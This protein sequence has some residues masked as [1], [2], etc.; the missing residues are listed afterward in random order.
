MQCTRLWKREKADVAAELIG[1]FTD[2]LAAGSTSQDVIDAF[3]DPRTAAKL[4]RRATIRKRPLLWHAWRWGGR[5]VEGV[6]LAYLLLFV[7]FY[8]SSP[9]ITTDYQAL[10]ESS[11]PTAAP[12]DCGFTYYERGLADLGKTDG[13]NLDAK[14]L[15]PQWPTLADWLRR[16]ARGIDLIRQGAAK[17][18]FGFSHDKHADSTTTDSDRSARPDDRGDTMFPV[19][20]P[21]SLDCV[22]QLD[23]VLIADIRLHAL[24]LEADTVENDL[25]AIQQISNQVRPLAIDAAG[26]V[27]LRSEL[28][29][30]LVLE[31]TLASHPALFSDQQLQRI[32]H[33]LS[34]VAPAPLP[35]DWAWNRMKLQDFLQR[36][37]TPGDAGRITWKGFQRSAWMYG[38][39][40][41]SPSAFVAVN[42][43]IY[44]ATRAEILAQYDQ[45]IAEQQAELQKPHRER[46]QAILDGQWVRMTSD[47]KQLVR[48]FPLSAA[49]PRIGAIANLA[50]QVRGQRDGALVGIALEI[51]HRRHGRY[52]EQLSDLTPDLLPAVPI[53]RMNGRPVLYRLKGQHPAG[54]PTACP[55]GCPIV[56]S[57][58]ADRDDDGG[59]VPVDIH[60]VAIPAAAIQWNALTPADGDWILY[61]WPTE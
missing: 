43:G 55:S 5:I 30:V 61:P 3:G 4:I 19:I 25:I 26:S 34:R 48:Y 8:M 18:V 41:V 35:I 7:R 47:P 60:G 32:A 14:P 37:F 6:L 21:A 20:E 31:E 29:L 44:G 45:I 38:T 9:R 46:S 28:A 49:I 56:Y 1:H 52:P 59:R 23:A 16:H 27:P 33:R 11:L 13:L 12:Q 10:R 51:Y 42:S 36:N 2:A 40:L 57:V 15:D 58:G 54:D 22:F 17:P 39:P 50:E 53:D 24:R